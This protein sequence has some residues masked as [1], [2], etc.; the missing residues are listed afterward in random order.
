MKGIIRYLCFKFPNVFM[1][2][3]KCVN[4]GEDGRKG[5]CK[6]AKKCCMWN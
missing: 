3:V 1:G 5:W 2:F 4:R 6:Y